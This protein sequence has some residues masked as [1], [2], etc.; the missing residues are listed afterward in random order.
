MSVLIASGS[1]ITVSRLTN[2]IL[3]QTAISKNSFKSGIQA[4]TFLLSAVN[5]AWTAAIA[6]STCSLEQASPSSFGRPPTFKPF[7]F[8]P[9]MNEEGRV[10]NLAPM[11]TRGKAPLPLTTALIEKVNAQIGGLIE[12]T[13]GGGAAIT[14]SLIQANPDDRYRVAGLNE[15]GKMAAGEP[16]S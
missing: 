3:S 13:R 14:A 2:E 5:A 4:G 11:I 15:A 16:A 7:W 10:V 9:E 1:L 12:K 6:S 8:H